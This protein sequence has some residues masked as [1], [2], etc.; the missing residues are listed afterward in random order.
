MLWSGNF[1][2]V[3]LT[4]ARVTAVSRHHFAVWTG[5]LPRAQIFRRGT[6]RRGTIRRG[7]IRRKKKCYFRLG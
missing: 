6:L 2:V 7:T 3:R 5:V 1:T 4:A